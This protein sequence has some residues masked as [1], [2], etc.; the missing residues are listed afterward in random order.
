MSC[1]EEVVVTET[2]CN[3]VQVA[4]PGPVGPQGPQG[5]PGPTGPAGGVT[6]LVAGANVTLS[7]TDGL[8]VVTV[9]ASGGGGGG[10]SQLV[11]G[12]N[13]TL[14]PTNGLG[15]VTISATGGA[16]PLASVSAN[17]PT[18]PENDYAPAGYV[19]GT[20]NRLLLTAAAGG[21]TLTGLVAAPDGWSILVRNMSE[22]DTIT[23]EHLTGSAS[24]NQFSLPAA[25]SFVI[26]PGQS[27][28]FEYVVNVWT[29]A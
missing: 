25:S 27:I 8:G 26:V 1:P 23:L 19:A 7:P 2:A 14:S 5:N 3:V 21:S 4:T 15:T 11:A 28:W 9:S 16:P 20:T 22:T 13:I 29:I 10:V 12:T 6:Q 17:V 24:A 18:G